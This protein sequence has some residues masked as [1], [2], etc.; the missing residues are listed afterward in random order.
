MV[1]DYYNIKYNKTRHHHHHRH[2]LHPAHS[3]SLV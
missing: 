3:R 1:N 2:P